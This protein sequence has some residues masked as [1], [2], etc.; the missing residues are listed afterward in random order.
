[1]QTK[2]GTELKRKRLEAKLSLREMAKLAHCTAPYLWRIEQGIS[3]PADYIFLKKLTDALSMTEN[4]AA[5]FILYAQDSQR[6]IKM[7]VDVGMT[8]LKTINQ[9]AANITKLGDEDLVAIEQILINACKNW[10][11][12]KMPAS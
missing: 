9:V 7:P 3:T 8:H 6:T 5:Q 11:D 2:V 1:M 10:K 12:K 4:E